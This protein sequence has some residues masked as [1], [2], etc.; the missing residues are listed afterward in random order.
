M[1]HREL[2]SKMVLAGV[3]M[4][5]VAKSIGISRQAVYRVLKGLRATPHVRR[6]V[7]ASIGLSYKDCW[8]VPDPE[9]DRLQRGRRRTLVHNVTHPP[10]LTP[11]TCA[12]Q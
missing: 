9:V 3:S 12:Q 5:D 4:A 6:A 2:R 11:P 8:G 7:A 1:N 10:A